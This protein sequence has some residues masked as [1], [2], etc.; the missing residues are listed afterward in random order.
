MLLLFLTM[1]VEKR[2]LENCKTCKLFYLNLNLIFKNFI[3][4]DILD[5]RKSYVEENE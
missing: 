4:W 5:Q 2:K 1:D 3:L